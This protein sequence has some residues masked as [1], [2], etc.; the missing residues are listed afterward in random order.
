[1][2][3]LAKLMR[4]HVRRDPCGDVVIQGKRGNIHL[5]GA[6]GYSVAVMLKTARKWNIVRPALLAF[7]ELQRDGNTEGLLSMSKLPAPAQAEYL[8]EVLRAR[9]IPENAPEVM[10]RLRKHG[11]ILAARGKEIT[12]FRGEN[13]S[14]KRL[15]V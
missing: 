10:E 12:A 7:C 5:D 9:N 4:V 1:M 14:N 6:G 11:R 13:Q 3:K 15:P 8:R 2:K